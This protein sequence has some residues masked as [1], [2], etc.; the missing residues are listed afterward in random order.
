MRSTYSDSHHGCHLEPIGKAPVIL[1]G[2]TLIY[3]FERRRDIQHDD[4][5]TDDTQQNRECRGKAH[6]VCV[7]KLITIKPSFSM[8]NVALLSVTMLSAV[9]L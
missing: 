4:T 3:I 5:L 7:I 9:L 6:F 8:Q 1:H 2:F